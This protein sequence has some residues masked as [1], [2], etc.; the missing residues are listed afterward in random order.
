MDF[1]ICSAAGFHKLDIILLKISSNPPLDITTKCPCLIE[2]S[3]LTMAAVE[4]NN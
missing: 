3:C 2:F 1:T 4:W